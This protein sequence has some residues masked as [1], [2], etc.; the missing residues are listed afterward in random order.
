GVNDAGEGNVISGN[1]EEGV[2][3][4]DVN[5]LPN[6]VAG[7]LIGLGADGTTP[8]GNASAGILVS[9]GSNHNRLGTNAD[10][11]SDALE[12]NVISAN[13]TDG[14]VLTGS[15]TSDNL[16]AGNYVGTD[17]AGTARRGNAQDG[18]LIQAGASNNTIGG[19]DPGARNVISGNNTA[20]GSG[21]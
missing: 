13:G 5:T 15:G 14:I 16:I 9:A 3:L 2:A 10:G 19:T 4:G 8:L 21:G 7:N 17:A 6:V 18:V 1:G 12:R 11:V 20:G